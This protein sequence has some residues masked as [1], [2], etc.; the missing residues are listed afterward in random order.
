MPASNRQPHSSSRPGPDARREQILRGAREACLE[1]GLAAVR[2]EQIA[3]HAHVSKGTLYNHFE[4]REDLLLAML[5]DRLQAGTEI[6]AGAVEAEPDPA[7]SLDRRIDALIQMIGFQAPTAP[8]LFQGWGLV[9]DAPALEQRF[10]QAL[11]GFFELWASS[12]R[13]ALEAGQATGAFRRDADID[14]FTAALLAL[15]S[16]SIFRGSVDP[17]AVEATALRAAFDAL[18]NDRLRLPPVAASGE[19]Q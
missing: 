9:A 11:R 16:G 1:R 18:L 3:A 4:S 17:E 19:F 6:V 2:M 13:E 5:E 8:L 10:K 7:R 15:V 12:T 14:A